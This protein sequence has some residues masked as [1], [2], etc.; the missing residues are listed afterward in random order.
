MFGPSGWPAASWPRSQPSRI[1]G[2][3]DSPVLKVRRRQRQ[4]TAVI[5]P[6]LLKALKP[7]QR[8]G[9]TSAKP[10]QAPSGGTSSSFLTR[11]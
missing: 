1:V 9:S 7:W 5:K 8:K 2:F 11:R 10:S 4:A 3:E 6:I